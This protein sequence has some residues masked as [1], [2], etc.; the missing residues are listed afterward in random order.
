MKSSER[1]GDIS[2]WPEYQL[3]IQFTKSWEPAMLADGMPLVSL[4]DEIEANSRSTRGTELRKRFGRIPYGSPLYWWEVVREGKTHCAY[5]G[6]TTR[7]SPQRRFESHSALV[8]LLSKYV[9]DPLA[10]VHFRLCSRLDLLHDSHR[11]AI[12]HLPPSQAQPIVDDIE[13]F[14]IYRYQP[15]FN[16]QLKATE[17]IPS[18]PFT[19]H[20]LEFDAV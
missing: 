11:L 8:R 2:T 15:E 17:R 12:E 19:V 9:N 14:L 13:G 1:I 10:R 18:K 4:F 5:I 7:Q 20:T 16:K 3:F 6:Q